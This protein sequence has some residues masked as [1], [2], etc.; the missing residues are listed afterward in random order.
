MTRKILLF[1]VKQQAKKMWIII[2]TQMI[3]TNDTPAHLKPKR[4][5]TERKS[6]TGA[7]NAVEKLMEQGEELI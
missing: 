1:K 3:V 7:S 4:L 2:S 5:M 6:N